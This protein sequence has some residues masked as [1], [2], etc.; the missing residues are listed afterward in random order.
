MPGPTNC[1]RDCA[2]GQTKEYIGVFHKD[3]LDHFLA[4]ES[5]TSALF[6][7]FADRIAEDHNFE[8]AD[9]S[10]YERLFCKLADLPSFNTKGSAD[11][12][13]VVYSARLGSRGPGA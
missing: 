12:A 3:I 11:N 9:E 8:I 1:F 10:D 4:T 7:K 5:S 13:S 6:R 2:V